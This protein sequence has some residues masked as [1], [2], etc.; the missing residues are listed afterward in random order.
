MKRRLLPLLCLL[1]LAV[2]CSVDVPSGVIPEDRMQDILYDYHLA[3]GTAAASP[4]DQSNLRYALVQSVFRKHGI[5]EAQ[6]DSSM[7]WYSGNSQYLLKMYTAI[8]ERIQREQALLGDDN[9]DNLYAS[10]G[11]DGDTAVIWKSSVLCLR[12]DARS[13]IVRF[14][15]E[16][17]STFRL[18]DSFTLRFRN[19]FIVQDGPRESYVTFTARFEGDTLTTYTMRIG[20]DFESTVQLPQTKLC[21]ERALQRLQVTFYFP[22]EEHDQDR[23]LFRLWLISRPMIIRFHN[24]LPTPHVEEAREDSVPADTLAHSLDTAT[25]RKLRDERLTPQ[26]MRD[27]HEG[28]HTIRV[29]KQ[30]RV[31]LPNN[32]KKQRVQK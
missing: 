12:N 13:N 32:K 27:S 5:T 26:Q 15:I 10:M 11:A 16:A 30:R 22:Y 9:I 7:V 18:G 6:F 4:S 31:N 28:E 29:T 19:S 17:D 25:A 3:Q 2:S 14:D 21:N 24:E 23:N 1:L 20:G 8:D